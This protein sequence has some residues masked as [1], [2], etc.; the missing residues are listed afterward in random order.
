MLWNWKAILWM[1]RGSV[2]LSFRQLKSILLIPPSTPRLSH[3]FLLYPSLS[4]PFFYSTCIHIKSLFF[5]TLRKSYSILFSI[6]AKLSVLMWHTHR[7]THAHT[8]KN[9]FRTLDMHVIFSCL[10]FEHGCLC[11]FKTWLFL[12]TSGD[13]TDVSDL[14]LK[15]RRA[16]RTGGS[17]YYQPY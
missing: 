14:P 2:A 11:Y 12:M 16:R 15:G 3:C 4:L 6:P 13:G 1:I 17:R 7:H 9:A 5:C 10:V 8:Q